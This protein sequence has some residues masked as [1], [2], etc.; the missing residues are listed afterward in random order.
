MKGLW[1]WASYSRYFPLPTI[2]HTTDCRHLPL[3]HYFHDRWPIFCSYKREESIL[4]LCFAESAL[5]SVAFST[6]HTAVCPCVFLYPPSLLASSHSHWFTL[7]LCDLWLPLFSQCR[8]FWEQEAPARQPP[9]SIRQKFLPVLS[10][11]KDNEAACKHRRC[12]SIELQFGLLVV[13][14]T[15]QN[16]NHTSSSAA[17][18]VAHWSTRAHS[19]STANRAKG[20]IWEELQRHLGTV[21]ILSR[22]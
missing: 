11:Q 1:C 3:F 12:R 15:T 22:S 20:K 2:Q 5:S 17:L 16:G 10:L 13:I 21:I 14:I 8:E 7:F 4:K 6:F 18:Q 9:Y 19:N